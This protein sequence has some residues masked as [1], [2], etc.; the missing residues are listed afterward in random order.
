MFIIPLLSSG[1]ILLTTRN[2]NIHSRKNAPTSRNRLTDT[3]FFCFRF[4]FSWVASSAGPIAW[5]W[6]WAYCVYVISQ[7]THSHTDQTPRVKRPSASTKL[8]W[9]IT[10]LLLIPGLCSLSRLSFPPLLRF[11]THSLTYILTLSFLYQPSLTY[12]KAS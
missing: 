7:S 12:T 11:L 3:F 5:A 2:A 6:A 1:P 9:I 8:V 4:F 10:T